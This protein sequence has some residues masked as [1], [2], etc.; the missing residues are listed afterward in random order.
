MDQ[1]DSIDNGLHRNGAMPS[2]EPEAAPRGGTASVVPSFLAELTRAMQAAAEQQRDQIAAVVAA[3]AA[4]EVDK[5]RARAAV[6]A[7]ELRRLAEQDVTG[8]KSW[9]AAET[10]RIRQEAGRRTDERRNELEA[11]LAKHDS[12]IATEIAGVDVA[13]SDYRATLDEFFDEL[14]GATN[15]AEIA[16]RAG[17][18]PPPPDLESVRAVARANAVA[19]FANAAQDDAEEPVAEAA[20]AAAE[21][22]EAAAAVAADVAVADDGAG[23]GV[24]DPDAIGRT[25][26]LGTVAEPAEEAVADEPVAASAAESDDAPVAEPV[27][28]PVA[29]ASV[30][31]SSAAVRLLRSIAPWTLTE[32][33]EADRGTQDSNR[34]S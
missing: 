11:H 9:M 31:H 15:P 17:S 27:A 24:M 26:D 16:R 7:D 23:L 30:Q 33:D 34:P 20:E 3:D 10:E 25:E 12:I 8:I 22:P 6:E 1:Y 14:R 18:L 28:E 19:S 13:V 21:E 5:A 32:D 2:S 29:A 4:G